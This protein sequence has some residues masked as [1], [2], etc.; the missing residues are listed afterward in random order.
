[1]DIPVHGEI[2]LSGASKFMRA[3]RPEGEKKLSDGR[4]R[5]TEMPLIPPGLA[6][7]PD[8]VSLSNAVLL[9]RSE[10]PSVSIFD[11]DGP[12]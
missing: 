7:Y 9:S 11:F 1:M 3:F 10:Y 8:S 12:R 5:G 4:T 6:E 2:A